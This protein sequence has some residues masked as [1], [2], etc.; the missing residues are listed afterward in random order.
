MK[1]YIQLNID[2]ILL[3]WKDRAEHKPLLLVRLANHL[4]CA[5][6]EAVSS[7]LLK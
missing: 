4:L 3:E 1:N 6:W 7:I 5:I 2:H